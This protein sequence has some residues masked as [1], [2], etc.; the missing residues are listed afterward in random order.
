MDLELNEQIKIICGRAGISISELARR[1]G[2]TPQNFTQQL[3]RNDFRVSD[4]NQIADVL[5]V[6]FVCGFE[7][8]KQA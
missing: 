3:K 1:L 7:Y 2:K 5:G 4:L 6:R 8:E